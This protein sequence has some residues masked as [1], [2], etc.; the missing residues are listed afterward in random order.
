M[1]TAK[2]VTQIRVKDPDSNA[3]VEISLFKHENGGMFALDSSY[4][5][6]VLPEEGDCLIPDPFVDEYDADTT[7]EVKLTGI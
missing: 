6:Q 1:D 7:M 4:I 5:E 3:P 2:F